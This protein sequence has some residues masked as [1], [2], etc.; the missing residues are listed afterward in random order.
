LIVASTQF[1]S[2]LIGVRFFPPGEVVLPLLFI[3]AFGNCIYWLRRAKRELPERLRIFAYRRYSEPEQQ[4]IF[5]RV[6]RFVGRWMHRAKPR[7]VLT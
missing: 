2:W 6:G 1:V 4:T 3:L 5:G 7:P